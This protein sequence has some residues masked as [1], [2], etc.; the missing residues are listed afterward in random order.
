MDSRSS[1]IHSSRTEKQRIDRRDL[2]KFLT[3]IICIL[4]SGSLRTHFSYCAGLTI[5][6]SP[7]AS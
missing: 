3:L 7:L 2:M 5:L 6:N 4:T 1:A